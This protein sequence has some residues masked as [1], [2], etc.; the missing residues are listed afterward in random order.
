[1]YSSIILFCKCLLEWD[2][3]ITVETLFKKAGVYCPVWLSLEPLEAVWLDSAY[4][5]ENGVHKWVLD[6]LGRYLVISFNEEEYKLEAFNNTRE[7]VIFH[8]IITKEYHLM[9]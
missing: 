4:S 3:I 1:M 2:I 7:Y 9:T 8:E 6:E 5:F